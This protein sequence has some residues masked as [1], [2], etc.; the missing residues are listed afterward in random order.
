MDLADEFE[1]A[2]RNLIHVVENLT[3]EQ[4]RARCEGEQC[5]VAALASHVAGVHPLAAR[6]VQSAAAGEP[7]PELTM[8]MVHEANA[9]QTAADANR[10]KGEILAALRQNGAEAAG[11]VRGLSDAELDRSTYF[12]LFDREMTTEELI[13]GVL[14][15][16]IVGHSRSIRQATAE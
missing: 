6:W 11:V 15:G 7:L 4:L 13:R 1:Q 14:I 10:D 9:K 3:P 8:D 2:S 12:K 16:D 5:T